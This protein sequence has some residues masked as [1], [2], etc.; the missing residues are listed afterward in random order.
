M[1]HPVFDDHLF[2]ME[3]WVGEV[4][5]IPTTVAVKHP[6][7]LDDIGEEK[8]YVTVPPR[9]PKCEHDWSTVDGLL[10]NPDICLKCGM[11]F[12]RYIHMEC[13]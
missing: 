11:S 1:K 9:K 3:A 4:R 2:D 7:H 12:T 13:P 8:I 5:P 10:G 6:F